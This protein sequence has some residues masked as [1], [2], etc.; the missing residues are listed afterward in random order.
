MNYPH[1][2]CSI[3]GVV[4]PVSALK[5]S[6][7]LGIGEFA[8]LVPLG[9]WAAKAGLSLIQILPVN[10]TGFE[11]SPYSALSA[12]ALHP[13]YARLRDFPETSNPEA[14][15]AVKALEKKL[16]SGTRTDFGAVLSE[17]LRVLRILWKAASQNSRN[18]AAAWAKSNPWITSYALFSFLREKQEL[19]SWKDWNSHINPT[20]EDLDALWKEHEERSGFLCM[21]PMETGRTAQSRGRSPG[22]EWV[23][24]LKA[25]FPF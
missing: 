18:Q 21:A 15:A 16:P 20:P 22:P 1:R 13:V 14:G 7:S 3:T 24:P 8:D 25:I 23:L 9:Q 19:R 5:S 12:F 17:K 11:R 2:D 4:V 10:D 6:R